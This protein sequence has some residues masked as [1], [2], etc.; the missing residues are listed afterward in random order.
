MS[1][2]QYKNPPIEEA[3]CEFV[4][5]SSYPSQ[6]FDLTVPGRLKMHRLMEEYS[7]EPRTQKISIISPNQVPT[8]ELRVQLPTADARRLVSIRHNAL[9][10]S[11][12][13]PYDGWENFKPRIER[14]L[15]AHFEAISRVAVTRIGVKYVN[16]IVVPRVGANPAAVLTTLPTEGKI[17]NSRLAN[18]TQFTEF[19]R[20]DEI[21][22][23]VT[24]ATLQFGAKDRTEYLLDIDMIWDHQ[25]LTSR[26][27][28]IEMVE[29][30]HDIEGAAFEALI[31][32]EARRLFDAG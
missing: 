2:K 26:N 17:S 12:L 8:I 31:T 5:A 7:G 14:T 21:K 29:K 24:Q 28:I 30:L 11:V 32:D 4:F 1:G 16:R 10:I 15:D 18:F 20:T 13:R 6:Q 19:V 23:L 9:A 27:E 3:V 22:V 25:A